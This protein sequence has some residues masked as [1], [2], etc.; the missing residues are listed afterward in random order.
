MARYG[1]Y[2]QL[3]IPVILL[4]V[5]GWFVIRN[6]DIRAWVILL[7]VSALLLMASFLL[8]RRG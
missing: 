8:R 3:L 2:R 1:S 4:V 5:A 6:V 7:I